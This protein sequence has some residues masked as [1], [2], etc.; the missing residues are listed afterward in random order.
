MINPKKLQE[1]A[2]AY[3]SFQMLAAWELAALAAPHATARL[4]LLVGNNKSIQLFVP[5]KALIQFIDKQMQLEYANLLGG[6]I[7]IVP[8]IQEVNA[9]REQINELRDEAARRG[10]ERYLTGTTLP[11]AVSPSTACRSRSSRARSSRW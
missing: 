3:S 7:D 5:C 9:A 4:E 11:T 1:L 2:T 8:F 10:V 6:G